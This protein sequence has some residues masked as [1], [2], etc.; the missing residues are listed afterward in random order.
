M[1]QD[2]GQKPSFTGGPEVDSVPRQS[3]SSVDPKQSTTVS[4]LPA[5]RSQSAKDA[6]TCLVPVSK[7]QN[8]GKA[9]A[10]FTSGGD[11][12][13]MNA[14]LRAIVRVGIFNEYKV[15]AVYEGY[16]GLVEGTCTCIHAQCHVY[17][18]VMAG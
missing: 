17:V 2:A 18:H 8:E 1:N 7:T 6:E 4:T 13:G 15:F 12:Q 9:I 16:Q 11:S 5:S 14:A 3:S 10:V